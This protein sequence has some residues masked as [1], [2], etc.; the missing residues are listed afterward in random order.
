[1]KAMILA[2][3]LGTRL[4]PLTADRPKALVPVGNEPVIDSGIAYLKGYGVEH[5]VVN[6]HHH[7]RLL[8]EHLDEGRP[9]GVPIQ[10]L[11]EPQI[12]D[13]G[14]GIRNASCF[15]DTSPFIVI[16]S[17]ILTDIDLGKAIYAHKKNNALVT[18]VLHDYSPFN[19]IA[20]D[21][22]MKITKIATTSRPGGLAFTGIHIIEPALMGHIPPGVPVSIVECYRELI[23]AEKPIMAHISK[24]HYWQDI[25][26]IETY[27]TANK[28]AATGNPFL[29]GSD[30]SIENSVSLGDWAVIGNNT[31]L[32]EGVE[33]TRSVLWEGVKV[34]RG[35][36]I[37]NSIVRSSKQVASDVIDTVF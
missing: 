33:I 24:D 34:K 14:G 28:R 2:A 10:V 23:N 15:L 18:M 3:G 1:M 13:T 21:E 31:V 37:I 20:V 16:N 26:T 22:H 27:L 5:I 35:T 9:F 32:E 30:C 6:A 17:D 11:V 25:G 19:Q 12:L 7:Y 4:R 29:V 8:E 36:R